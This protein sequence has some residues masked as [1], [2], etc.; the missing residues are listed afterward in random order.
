MFFLA[1]WQSALGTGAAYVALLLVALDRF[2]SPWAIGLIL[3]ADVL[4]A[5]LLGPVFGAFA[6]RFSRKACAVIADLIRAGAFA[7]IVITDGFVLTF[8]LS[9]LAGVGTGLFNPAA[10]A[11]LPSLVD[12]RR[13]AAATSLFGA[14][15]DFGFIAGPAAAAAVLLFG[16]PETILAVNAISFS[17]SAL[18]LAPLRYGE[19]PR[20][21]DVT[22]ARPS[23][24]AEAREGLIATAGMAGLRLVLAASGAALLFGA[25]FNVGQ[26][27]LV[28]DVLEGGD[29]GFAVLVTVY[30]LGFIAGSLSGARGGDLPALKRRYLAGIFLMALG[31]AASGFAPSV[32]PAG[33]A[34][35][36]AGYGNGLL[37]VYERLLIQ[38]IVPDR[39][40]GRVF[41]IRDAITAWAFATGFLLGPLLISA[42]GTRRLIIAGGLC[43]LVVWLVSAWALRRVWRL[44]DLADHAS[45]KFARDRRTGEHS[46][47]FVGR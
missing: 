32:A 44:E 15:A 25:I 19:A 6:D 12:K 8:L 3:L 35:L 7:G 16:G 17:V 24:L 13:L 20:P 36:A 47:D 18:L 1:L 37:L 10:L 28:R 30:G 14:I 39:L 43:G 22:A 45:A 29:V 34:F 33:V 40:A 11:S 21:E 38:A 46:P 41:G 9:L 27:L 2:D 26:P 31:F 42:V 23:L 5:M 4:P